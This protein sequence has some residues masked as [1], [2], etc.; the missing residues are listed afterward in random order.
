MTELTQIQPMQIVAASDAPM[1]AMIERM[2]MD[3]NASIEKLQAMLEMKE[4]IDAATARK[5]F[6]AAISM[7][8]AAIPPILKNKVVDFTSAKGRTNYRHEDLAEIARTVDPILSKHGLSYRFRTSQ[9][10]QAVSVTCVMSHALGHFEE[11][12][13][14][15]GRDESGNKNSIQA[16]GSAIT[17]LQRYTLKAALGLSVTEDDD[18]RKSESKGTISEDQYIALRALMDQAGGDETKFLAFFKIDELPELPVAKYGEAD[19]MLRQ[20]IKKAGVA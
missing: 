19:A 17:Y 18:G 14:S 3:P 6:D 10:G 16:V 11:T 2:V 15:A 20:K 12:V 8:K 9:E 1:V 7:A 5:A 4:R 13:L